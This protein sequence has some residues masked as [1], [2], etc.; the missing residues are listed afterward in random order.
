M[1]VIIINDSSNI[2]TTG[3]MAKKLNVS[4]RTLV[5]WD[6]SKKLVAH[7]TPTN[8][9]F[10]TQQ[11]VNEVLGI[12]P[13][14]EST[15]QNVAYARVSSRN[16]KDDLKNQ[17]QFIQNFVNAKGIILDQTLQDIGSGLNYN[18][19]NWNKLLSLVMNDQIQTIYITYQDRFIRFGYEWFERLCKQ[20]H[21]SI[22]VLNQK[23]SS[24]NEEFVQDIISII[25]V[26][27]C[28]LYGLRK[29]QKKIENDEI[30]KKEERDET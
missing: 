9:R 15:R 30:I 6:Q 7:R 22:V 10:Y 18:R 25:H 12:E 28:R 5:N 17:I 21:T 13:V 24:P 27:S 4:T 8:Q 11:Q 20:H 26:F 14:N 3:Q 1:E 2:Y 23:K 29:Y 16:Q 19:K